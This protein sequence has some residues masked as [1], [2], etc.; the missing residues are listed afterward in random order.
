M[1][2]T[3]HLACPPVATLSLPPRPARSLC[4]RMTFV[5]RTIFVAASLASRLERPTAPIDSTTPIT[6]IRSTHWHPALSLNFW[7]SEK[8]SANLYLVRIFLFRNAKFG[9]ER[10]RF[11]GI[12]GAKSKFLSTCN[13]FCRKFAVTVGKL[14]LSATS[15]LTFVFILSLFLD[16]IRF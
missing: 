16:A 1:P 7:L 3:A 10:L 15:S 2:V 4:P 11:W 8:S 13:L 14:Q 5:Q 12:L 9:T 6:D